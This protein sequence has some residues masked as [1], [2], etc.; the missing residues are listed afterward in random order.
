M[1]FL[2]KPS[3]ALPPKTKLAGRVALLVAALI[4]LM[5]VGQLFTFEKFPSVIYDMWLP[6]VSRPQ[7]VV[8]AALIVLGE[9]FALPFLLRMRLS[10][11]MRFLSM[12]AGW[13]TVLFWLFAVVW[14]NVTLTALGN[15]GLLGATVGLMV[16]WWT[17]LLMTAV[18]ILVA[19][20]SWG[21]WPLRRRRVV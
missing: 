15:A 17:A 10:P 20:A 14:Q 16:G 5:L 6:G 18:A 2:V 21:L 1:S 9:L 7:S 12:V 19:W 8:V 4:V 3:S 11:A 13:L